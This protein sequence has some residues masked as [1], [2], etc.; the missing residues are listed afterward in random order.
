MITVQARW[1]FLSIYWNAQRWKVWKIGRDIKRSQWK[2]G[3]CLVVFISY[4]FKKWWLSF[5]ESRILLKRTKN[6][7]F[8]TKKHTSQRQ[9]RVECEAQP[10][11]FKKIYFVCFFLHRL[12]CITFLDTFSCSRYY[13]L[14]QT[15]P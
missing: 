5:K 7:Y 2:A 3:L 15:I 10:S 1:E 9:R 8:S 11:H 12:L 14:S 6:V 4:I 13:N